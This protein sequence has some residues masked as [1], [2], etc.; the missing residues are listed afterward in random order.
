MKIIIID[1]V[2]E[3][4]PSELQKLGFDVADMQNIEAKDVTSYLP[5]FQGIVIR[6][7]IKLTAEILSNLPNLKFIARVG[8]GMESIDVE[9]AEKQGIKLINAPEGNRDSVGEHALGM[10]LNLFNKICSANLQVKSGIWQREP[11]RGIELMGKTVGI[12]GYGNMGGAFAR[13]LSGFG[14]NVI[15]YD[16]YKTN[17]S[18]GFTKEVNLDDIFEQTDILSLHVPLQDDTFYM[19]DNEFIGKFKKPFYIINTARGK[20]IKTDDLVENLKSGKILG[21]AL[22]V[23]EYEKVSFETLSIQNNPAIEYLQNAENVILTPHVAGLTFDSNLKLA[24]VI[25]KKILNYTTN[26]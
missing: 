24:Q 13:R 20:N 11:N 6:S 22:D 19:I 26:A 1:K 2:H 5:D 16:K 25:V 23:L 7:K 10:I 3:Y 21:A 9:F 18:D 8:A 17:Y 14:V 12:I 4:L 15:S